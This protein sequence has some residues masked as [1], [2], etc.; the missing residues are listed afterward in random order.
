MAVVDELLPVAEHRLVGDLLSGQ[1]PAGLAQGV[2]QHQGALVESLSLL[3]TKAVLNSR[4]IELSISRANFR[5][6]AEPGFPPYK[7]RYWR[8]TSS[9]ACSS[10]IDPEKRT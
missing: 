4:T 8:R 7:P 10:A 2:G 9:S 5:A 6:R 1:S 3:R